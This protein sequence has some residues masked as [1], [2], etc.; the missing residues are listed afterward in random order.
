[1]QERELIG[2]CQK[3]HSEYFWELYETYVDQIYK[4]IYLKTY[5]EELAQDLTSETFLKAFDKI[6]TFKNDEESHFKAWIYRIAYNLVIDN[7]KKQKEKVD[8]DE[9]IETGYSQDFGKDIDN[10]ETLKEVFAYFDTL[11]QKHK[12]ILIMRLWDDL[13]YKEISALSWESV[14]N[15]KK[16]VSRTLKKVPNTQIVMLLIFLLNL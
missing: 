9:I 15:C 8:I 3:W 11:N 13:S 4:F 12:D 1:M 2:L 7:Y 10:K 16:I 6:H 5:Q 14:D